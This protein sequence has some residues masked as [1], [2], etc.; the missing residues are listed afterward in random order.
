M[1]ML[2]GMMVNSFACA[3]RVSLRK[4][5]FVY[6]KGGS[7]GYRMAAYCRIS[8]EAVHEKLSVRVMLDSNCMV[9]LDLLSVIAGNDRK[10]ASQ[11]LARI[12]SKPETAA[13]LTLRHP[14][15]SSGKRSPRKLISFSNAIQLLLVLPKRTADLVTRR[16][17]AG[18]L[19]DYFEAE[20][21]VTDHSVESHSWRQA[22]LQIEQRTAELE[23]KSKQ[24]S[25]DDLKSY[26][27]LLTQCGPLK[28]GEV[29]DF[30]RRV[31][32]DLIS[33]HA[34]DLDPPVAVGVGLHRGEDEVRGESKGLVA[35]PDGPV[36]R[37]R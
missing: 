25:L 10:R 34:V 4:A 36:L 9:A 35:Q 5:A 37:V 30:K 8:F 6:K 7:A 3:T 31:A 19:A 1:K 20:R 18:I 24:H 23:Q 33:P 28:E 11:T 32:A 29:E 17:V 21:A 16:T 2:T 26:L 15:P 14:T 27:D 22:L 13:L 12:A